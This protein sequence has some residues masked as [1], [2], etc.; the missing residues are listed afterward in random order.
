MI[1][2]VLVR[3]QHTIQIFEGGETGKRSGRVTWIG[4]VR[5]GQ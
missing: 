4:S 2:E 1:S 3:I 5:D